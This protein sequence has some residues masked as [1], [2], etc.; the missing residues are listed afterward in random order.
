M[1]RKYISTAELANAV[2]V[3]PESIRTRV[4]RTGAYFAVQPRKGLN[5]RLLWPADAIDKLLGESGGQHG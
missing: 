1:L 3:K 5:G 4:Y 2:G